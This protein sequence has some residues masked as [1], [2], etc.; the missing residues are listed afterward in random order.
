MFTRSLT[1]ALAIGADLFEAGARA[2]VED[3][4]GALALLAQA[5]Q[6]DGPSP[7]QRAV[8][9]SLDSGRPVLHLED[10]EGCL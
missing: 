8:A 5:R 3:L 7:L 1:L 10:A 4:A 2:S 6:D 9:R